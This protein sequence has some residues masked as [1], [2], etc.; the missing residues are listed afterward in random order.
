MDSTDKT[1]TMSMTEYKNI[2]QKIDAFNAGKISIS[3][4]NRGWHGFVGE[5]V[6]YEGPDVAIQQITKINNDLMDK[7]KKITDEY[8]SELRKKMIKTDLGHR[9]RFLFTGRVEYEK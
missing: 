1:V 2:E 8:D 5:Q 9:F 7:N 6:S 3:R 4:V